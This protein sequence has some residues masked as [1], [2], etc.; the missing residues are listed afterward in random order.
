MA[1]DELKVRLNFLRI[2]N[3]PASDKHRTIVNLKRNK[4]LIKHYGK[5]FNLK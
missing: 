4:S 2:E 1:S 3:I 5:S